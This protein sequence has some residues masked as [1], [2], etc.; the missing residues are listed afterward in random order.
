MSFIS[1]ISIID[2]P[3]KVKEEV[4]K[5]YARQ[6]FAAH[7]AGMDRIIDI[8]DNTEISYRNFCKPLHEYESLNSFKDQNN[9]YIRCALEYSVK[10]IN[11][12][13][14]SAKI[15]K[16]EI[17][18]IIFV[19]TTGL[20]TPSLDALIINKLRLNPYINRIPI[21]GLGCAGG[22]S[23]IAKANTLA[24]ANPDAIVLVV[25]V[26]L[27][28][29]TFLKNDFSKSNFVAS[30]LF[31]DGIAAC[32]VKGGNHNKANTG[33]NI[34]ASGSKLYY[35][36]LDVMGWEFLDSGFKVLF[37]QDIPAIIRQHV[38]ED[39]TTFLSKNNL[40]LRDIK[41]FIFHPGG[42]KVIGAYEEALNI[43]DYELKNTKKIMNDYGNM[44]SA[45]VVYVMDRFMKEGFKNGYGL[46]IALG[47][48][49]S[50]EMVLLDMNRN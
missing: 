34:I 42:K 36:S 11:R 21:F 10:A 45:T 38:E 48:G 6:H 12:S 27:C 49:F 3:N 18:D 16:E 7:F 8:F 2:F 23:G 13:I 22:V 41:N 44:S 9:E 29:L 33:I 37:S 4:V 31:S 19:S 17:S 15:R 39:I 50:S 5:E 40:H 14:V 25:A 30:S 46:M 32:I 24:K 1:S 28:S 47:P 43:S 26:E 35:D 20:A